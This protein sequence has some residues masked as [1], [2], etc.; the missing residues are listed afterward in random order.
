MAFSRRKMFYSVVLVLCIIFF[1]GACS[2]T[3]FL[4]DTQID[5]PQNY[6]YIK[7]KIN[8]V[9]EKQAE[10]DKSDQP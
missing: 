1:A 9:I 4:I 10:S 8:A 3:E 2:I 7:E 6:G 5:K